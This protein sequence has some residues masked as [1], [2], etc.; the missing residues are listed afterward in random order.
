MNVG[1]Y[2]FT[3]IYWTPATRSILLAR[4]VFLMLYFDGKNWFVY[5]MM[6]IN[7]KSYFH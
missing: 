2:Y 5:P 6:L 1:S 7:E 3:R 4:A